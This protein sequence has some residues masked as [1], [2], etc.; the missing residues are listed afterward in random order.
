[1]TPHLQTEQ[2]LST[3]TVLDEV[4]KY[5]HYF[6]HYLFI[7][8]VKHSLT[9]KNG[10]IWVLVVS[11]LIRGP[12][13]SAGIG[14]TR[15]DKAGFTVYFEHTVMFVPKHFSVHILDI[16]ECNIIK[17]CNV[18][19]LWIAFPASNHFVGAFSWSCLLMWLFWSSCAVLQKAL[20]SSLPL[21][22]LVLI[23][24]FITMKQYLV[25]YRALIVMKNLCFCASW[26]LSQ[27]CSGSKQMKFQW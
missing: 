4:I 19:N 2:C 17:I 24:F 23:F 13:L 14:L 8:N 18:I 22:I 5:G 7:Q 10:C 3:V 6:F 25:L 9:I 26:A 11:L 21:F 12:F 15:F 16:L 27:I 1:M 20:I